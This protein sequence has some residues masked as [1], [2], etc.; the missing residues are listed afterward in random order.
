VNAALQFTYYYAQTT[1]APIPSAPTTS[2]STSA[3][4]TNGVTVLILR[5]FPAT[6]YCSEI[7]AVG[8]VGKTTGENTSLDTRDTPIDL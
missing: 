3:P 1:S 8:A 7:D 6:L 4:T 2:A 5:L